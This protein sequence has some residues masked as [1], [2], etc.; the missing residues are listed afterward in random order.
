MYYD[1]MISKLCTWGATRA[2]AITGM[3]RALEDFH[4]EGLGHNIPFLSAVMDQA[5]FQSGKITT[6]YIAEEFPD[7]FTGAAP[8]A[9]QL[10]IVTAVGGY[11]Q[12]LI[13]DRAS[14]AGG[15]SQTRTDW[16]VIIGDVHRHVTLTPAP[17]NCAT[18]GQLEVL[19]RLRAP[20]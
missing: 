6:G 10:D 7:G 1:P 14:R 5:R 11:V 18:L 8:T 9:S 4:I 13:A 17:A 15:G 20:A 19:R 12:R 3:A 2:E 16:V